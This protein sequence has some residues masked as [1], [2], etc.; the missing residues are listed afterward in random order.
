MRAHGAHR[1][2]DAIV[3]RDSG[4]ALKPLPAMVE[5]ALQACAVMPDD[6]AFVGDS[7]ADLNAAKSAAVRFYGINA[8]PEGR[9]RLTT[10]GA[11]PVFSSPSAM[12]IYLDLPATRP[13]SASQRARS[14]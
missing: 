13:E 3:G 5:R 11:S 14:R 4:L 7:E 9:D 1:L 10:L 8:K 6:A 12:A 2:F